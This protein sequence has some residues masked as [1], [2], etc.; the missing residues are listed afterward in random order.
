MNSAKVIKLP[1]HSVQ[2]LLNAENV[3][4]MA[5]LLLEMAKMAATLVVTFVQ[6]LSFIS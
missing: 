6:L 4:E 3:R 5:H 2:M 1:L